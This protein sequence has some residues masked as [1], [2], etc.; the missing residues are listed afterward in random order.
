MSEDSDHHST[1]SS[2][3]SEPTDSDFG[4]PNKLLSDGRLDFGT[5]HVTR[6]LCMQ[7]GA[8]GVTRL[9]FVNVPRF[10][11]IIVSS[12]HCRHCGFSGRDVQQ[13]ADIQSE[14]ARIELQASSEADLSRG[15]VKGSTCRVVIH[16][17][18]SPEPLVEIEPRPMSGMYTTVEGLL[19][20][21]VDNLS[22]LQPERRQRDPAAAARID[23]VLLALE[24]LLSTHAFRVTLDDPTGNSHVEPLLD[25][26]DRR[27]TVTRYTRSAA[28]AAA[29]GLDPEDGGAAGPG[30]P[31]QPGQPQASA[32]ASASTPA[33]AP[34]R[35][36]THAARGQSAVDP[37]KIDD[38]TLML[39]QAPEDSP[40]MCLP[41]VCPVCKADVVNKTLFIN[42]PYFKDVVLMAVACEEC[43]YKSI[44]VKGAGAI[45][46][47]GRSTTLRVTGPDDLSRDVLKS[48]TCI[49]RLPDLGLEL[50]PGTLGGIYTTLEGLLRTIQGELRKQSVYWLGDSSKDSDQARRWAEL[51]QGLEEC[52][53][54][55]RRFTIEVD[56]PLDASFI[57]NI[58]APEPDPEMVVRTYKRTPE[59]DE[60]Y[61][62]DA[63]DT[64]NFEAD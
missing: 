14:G 42:I 64:E 45:S 38:V 54:G 31:G 59:Q 23:Q 17:P 5:Q 2:S 22:L 49:V 27:L 6:S 25:G 39:D 15:V 8:Q 30:E 12:F 58:Y 29:I 3:S 33:Q 37:R 56:D 63:M 28:Q 18:G 57:K 9:L 13:A 47:V 51:L 35:V 24:D 46:L 34:A 41:T 55:A 10:S 4:I 44:D 61:G 40:V 50:Q 32:S 16:A 52:A 1:S 60:E 53:N 43:G 21:T 36:Q 48:D 11:D 26:P 19:R 62:L 7:C 20:Q